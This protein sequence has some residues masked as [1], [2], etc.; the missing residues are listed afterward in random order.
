MMAIR[1]VELRRVLKDTGSIYLHCDPTAGPY[2]RVMMDSVF[3]VVNFRNEIVWKR[4]SAHSDAKRFGQVTDT[5]FFYSRSANR[6]W[7]PASIQHDAKY[8]SDFYRFH[9]ERGRYRLHEII[10]T[11]SMGP[12]PNLVYEYKGYTPPWG[13][14][15]ERPKLEALDEEGRLVWAKS[16]RPYRKTYLTEG[17]AP[18]NLWTDVGNVAAQ[19]KE[20]L[21]YPTQ[22]PLALLERIV[23]ASSNEGDIVLDPFCGC[24]TAVHAAQKLNRRWIGIDITHLAIGLI[25]R[26]MEDAF[27]GLEITVIGEPVDLTG[28]RELAAKD[29]YQF[30]WWALDRLGAQPVSGKKK[31][32]DKGIDGVIPFFESPQTDYKRALVSVKGG[33]HVTSQMVRDLR[34]VI[35]RENEPLGVFVTLVP[36]TRDMLVEAAAAGHYH[37]DFWQKGYPRIQILTIEEILNGKRPQMPPQRS[38]FAKAPLEREAAKT[39]RML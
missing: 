8:E 19:A 36:P 38:P 11:A 31:G 34:G 26:R 15:M 39:E 25:R 17:R 29:K 27:P 2:L 14:R 28:A 5:I 9:D 23:A 6:V 3:G 7:N 22:K 20:R 4:T 32:S 13:W 1:L 33:E 12:R 30:Q 10:R 21:G 24:G 35:E 37:N 16:G 18:T